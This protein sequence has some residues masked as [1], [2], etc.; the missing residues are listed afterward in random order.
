MKLKQITILTVCLLLPANSVFSREPCELPRYPLKNGDFSTYQ[1]WARP[2]GWLIASEAGE[3]KL[4]VDPVPRQPTQSLSVAVVSSSSAGQGYVWQTVELLEGDWRL[5]VEVAGSDG[6][7]AQLE[8]SRSVSA[9]S[10]PVAVSPE[11]QTLE[12]HISQASGETG[13]HLRFYSP[14][15]GTVKFRRAR[16]EAVRLHSEPVPIE[17]DDV[18]GGLVLAAKPSP[19]ERYAAYELQCFVHQMTG[20]TPGIAGRDEVFDGRRILIGAAARPQVIDKLKGLPEDAYLL[21]RDDSAT[22]LAGNSGLSTLYAVYDLLNHQG[23]SWVI[24]GETG[25]VVPRRKELA[26]SPSRVASPDFPLVRSIYTGFQ[27]FFPQ[28]GWI[29]I[30]L[31]DYRDWAVRNRFNAIW[32]GGATL[33]LGADLGHG[34]IQNSGHSWNAII[35]PHE[36]F[37][38]KHPQWY[39]LV[40][41]KRM[42]RSDVS[43]RLPNQLCVSNRE[44]RDYTVATILEYFKKNPRSRMFPMNPMDGPNYNCECDNCRA[45]D[46]PGYVWNQDFSELPQ[47]PNLK[48][49]P[50]SD[51]YLNYVNHVAERI[52]RIYPDKLIEFYNYAS[53]VPPSR[54]RV[55]PNVSVKFTYLSGRE[56]NVSLTDPD[57]PLARKERSWL[58]AWSSSGTRRM[59]YYPYTDWEHPDAAVHWYLNLSDLLRNLKTRYGC[60]G[61]MGETHTTVHADPIWWAIYARMLWDVDVD[62]RDIIREV[63]SAYYGD[64]ANEMTR[65]HL[66]MDAAVIHREGDRP[67]NYHPNK[68]LEFSLDEIERGRMLLGYAAARAA[69]NPLSLRRV[70]QA[71]F[72]HALLTLVR[73][74][75]EPNDS[76]RHNSIARQARGDANALRAK[77]NIMVKQSTSNALKAPH[78]N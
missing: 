13:I 37:F 52:A 27:Q 61:T 73:L 24:P 32:T 14:S 66:A 6:A 19:A 57:D 62:Y 33:D 1:G 7:K 34:W 41:G 72:A 28:G 21:H 51:R 42:P 9:Q 59:T 68:R 55:H 46:P 48:L 44:L 8:V 2:A 11:W 49:P 5:R 18:L 29:Y 25:E 40:N 50:L 74:E 20:K 70:D 78:S 12:L 38:D 53:R 43:I 71:R 22:T 69:E 3:H 39:P 31:D 36:K 16:L 26:A 60:V 4:T 64:A 63:C 15:G 23:C 76:P 17:G 47:F 45:L 77:Y 56:I 65:F 35:A 30:D 54:E 67:A 75:N 58:N 10:D